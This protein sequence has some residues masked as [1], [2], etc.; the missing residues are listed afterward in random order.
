VFTAELDVLRDEGEAYAAKLQAAG[1]P[2]EHIRVPS[3]PHLYG[4]LDGILDGGKKYNEKVIA[5]LK[6]NLCG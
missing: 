5:T 1:T 4:Q 3:M 2:V 6:K